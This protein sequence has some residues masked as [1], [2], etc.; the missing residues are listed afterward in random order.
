MRI[1]IG[2]VAVVLVLA[3]LVVVIGWL[4][5]VRHRAMREATLR[6]T[7]D[8]LF[9]LITTPGDF[10]K[11]RTGIERLDVLPA[12][13]G[14]PQYREVSSSGSILY[15]VV[16][17]VPDRELVTEIA[18][19]TLPFGGRWTY[20]LIPVSADSTTL[21][22]TEDGAVYNPVFR[23]ISRF[24]IGHTATIARYL[25]DVERRI[26]SALVPPGAPQELPVSLVPPLCD[27][28]DLAT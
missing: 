15:A 5:P 25:K 13:D 17:S 18:D 22:I 3:L 16:R 1:A 24:V 6:T 28:F 11:W 2:A 23:F 26:R 27:G 7:P 14:H 8:R 9:A 20:E 12:V 4:L 21:R 19:R 10:P